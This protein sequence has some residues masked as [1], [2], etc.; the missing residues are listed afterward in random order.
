ML[1]NTNNELLAKGS[2]RHD[3][4]R[5]ISDAL[6]RAQKLCQDQKQ[7]LTRTR[8]QVL[9]LI[10]Q[11]HQPVGAYSIMDTLAE[12]EGKR[13]APP[14]V[15]R[16]LDFLLDLGLIHR[17]NSLN[18]YIGCQSPGHQHHSCFLICQQCQLA[19]E[20]EPEL[21]KNQIE[22]LQQHSGFAISQQNIELLGTCPQCQQ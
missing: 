12:S 19:L 10:W 8:E 4:E 14:T 22:A 11:S 7:R 17:I 5:C 9:R 15:Y 6:I 1:S 20:F 2:E 21:L 3:H 13:V 18:A 16:A